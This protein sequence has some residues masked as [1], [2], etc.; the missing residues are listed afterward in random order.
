MRWK[1]SALFWLLYMPEQALAYTVS[2]FLG[3]TMM[4]NMSESK[5]IPLLMLCQLAPPSVVF[6]GRC[7]V[8]A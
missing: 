5:A 4:L 8:P 6:H 2:G 7:Q 3:S 1:S